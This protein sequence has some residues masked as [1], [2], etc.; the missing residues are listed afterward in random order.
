MSIE[1]YDEYM[2]LDLPMDALYRFL[3]K[4]TR[5]ERYESNVRVVYIDSSRMREMNHLFLGIDEDTDVL[6]FPVSGEMF[7]ADNVP[8]E[9]ED[10]DEVYISVD[11]V[12]ENAQKYETGFMY[13]I[14]LVTLHGILHLVGFDDQTEEERECMRQR[15]NFY[16]EKYKNLWNI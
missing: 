4:V 10:F 7:I 15:E 3:K 13:E 16:M 12:L 5:G 14:F 8:T 6:S 9:E 1:L 11:K 2:K